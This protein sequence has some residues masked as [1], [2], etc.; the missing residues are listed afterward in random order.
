MLDVPGDATTLEIGFAFDGD[1]RTWLDA[2]S[3]EAR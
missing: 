2:V 3:L 1:G